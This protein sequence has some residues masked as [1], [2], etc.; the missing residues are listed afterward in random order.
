MR[1][2]I[3]ALDGKNWNLEELKKHHHRTNPMPT[4][5]TDKYEEFKKK[6]YTP[7]A[8]GAWAWKTKIHRGWRDHKTQAELNA[9]GTGASSSLHTVLDSDGQPASLAADVVY[10][11]NK[12]FWE[13]SLAPAFFNALRIAANNTGKLQVDIPVADPAHVIHADYKSTQAKSIDTKTQEVM[14]SLKSE[15]EAAEVV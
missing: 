13:G 11:S 10:N 1:D 4:P 14:A 6:A 8:E 9:K 12:G 15:L 3:A 2:M 5:G 7:G